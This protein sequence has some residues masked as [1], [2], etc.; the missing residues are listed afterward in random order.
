LSSRLNA[1]SA[2]RLLGKALRGLKEW[3]KPPKINTDQAPAYGD[4]IRQLKEEGKCPEDL[5]HR[6]VKYLNNR[7]EADHGKLK[8]LINPVRGFKSM[9]TTY[10][11]IKGFEVMYMFKKGQFKLWRYGQGLVGEIR[12][13]TNCLLGF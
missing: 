5:E 9:K 8:R 10:A 1:K 3:V 4:E 6:Q 7:A 12:L 13:I 11:K 2:K